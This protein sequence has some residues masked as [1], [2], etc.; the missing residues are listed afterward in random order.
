MKKNE[1]E[2]FGFF[3]TIEKR[4]SERG[5]W[6]GKGREKGRE[7]RTCLAMAGPLARPSRHER[8]IADCFH[9]QRHWPKSPTSAFELTMAGRAR[10]GARGKKGAVML[11]AWLAKKRVTP[12]FNSSQLSRSLSL[13]LACLLDSAA[14]SLESMLSMLLER[15]REKEVALFASLAQRDATRGGKGETNAATA[16]GANESFSDEVP[17]SCGSFPAATA[18][19]AVLWECGTEET[20]SRGSL[21]RSLSVGGVPRGEGAGDAIAR[22]RFLAACEKKRGN[23]IKEK[24]NLSLQR[25][26]R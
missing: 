8:Q 14:E 6:R 7:K 22:R 17:S 5:F 12:R 16:A 25:N 4:V 18:L 19:F 9:A 21:R 3:L 23:K 10:R 13:K 15:G 24:I 20:S 1:K 11:S 2:S 26:Q